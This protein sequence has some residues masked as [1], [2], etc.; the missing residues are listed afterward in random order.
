[1]PGILKRKGGKRSPRLWK[2]LDLFFEALEVVGLKIHV[3]SCFNFHF[4]SFHFQFKS[5]DF[6]LKS[7][8]FQSLEMRI[9]AGAAERGRGEVNFS[10]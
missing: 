1:M 10:P 6:R 8:D 4:K 9:R 7:G 3:F 5:F 2:L